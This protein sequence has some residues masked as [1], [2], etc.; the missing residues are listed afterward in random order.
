[1]LAV[2]LERLQDNPSE[3]RSRV[4]ELPSADDRSVE[5]R[6]GAGPNLIGNELCRGMN[7]GESRLTEACRDGS[8][9]CDRIG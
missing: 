3:V 7:I 5:R 4:Q 6:A 9:C 1:M 8:L 2:E